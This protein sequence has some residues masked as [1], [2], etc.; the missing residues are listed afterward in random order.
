MKFPLDMGELH[1]LSA[2]T[3]CS[4]ADLQL[5]HLT[6]IYPGNRAYPL[7]DHITVAPLAAVAQV[8]GEA[9]FLQD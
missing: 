6:V 1:G 8:G 2:P 4:M 9:L 7:A 5:D 3:T